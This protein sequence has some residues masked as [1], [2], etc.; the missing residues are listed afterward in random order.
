MKIES[1]IHIRG[2]YVEIVSRDVES[3]VQSLNSKLSQEVVP[4]I[5]NIF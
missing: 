5:L 1:E 2:F 3:F 4:F